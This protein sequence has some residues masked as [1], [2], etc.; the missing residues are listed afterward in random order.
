VVDRRLIGYLVIILVITT[1]ITGLIFQVEE[2]EAV[3]ILSSRMPD[4]V[5][6]N[7][8][9]SRSYSMTIL[10]T[11]DLPD[12]IVRFHFLINLTSIQLAKPWSV[13]EGRE[14]EDLVD[15]VP[16]IK[17]LIDQLGRLADDLGI[18]SA[19]T[20]YELETPSMRLQVV[21]FSDAMSAI[22]GDRALRTVYTVYAF[23]IGPGDRVSVLAGYRDFFV[24]AWDFGVTGRNALSEI[25]FASQANS[26]CY[27]SEDAPGPAEGCDQVDDA[28]VGVIRFRDLDREDSVQIGV[29]LDTS[30]MFSHSGI[31]QIITTESGHG[32][33]PVLVG[34]IGSRGT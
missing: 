6:G 8:P 17:G 4:N 3:R 7:R 19:Y 22:A 33:G 25:S 26:S 20:T 32:S 15:N 28:P 11:T 2:D 30:K 10:A 5:P 1:V 24:Y 21:D 12:L 16:R 31:V 23:G 14:L 34:R 18:E 29:V 13:Q 27:R 9:G